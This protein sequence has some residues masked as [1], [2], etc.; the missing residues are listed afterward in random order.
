MTPRLKYVLPLF[1]LLFS[2]IGCS[3][4][5]DSDEL[6]VGAIL[7]LTGTVAFVGEPEKAALEIALEDIR[8]Q[9]GERLKVKLFIEDSAGDAKTAVTAANKL[10]DID[11]VNVLFVSLS[12]INHAVAPAIADRKVLHFATTTS[13]IGVTEMTP[14]TFR[15]YENF[16]SEMGLLA[17]YAKET[18][19]KE[20]IGVRV[21]DYA[22][23][24]AFKVLEQKADS[25]GVRVSEGAIFEPGNKDYRS[26]LQ[27]IP[28]NL[29]SDQALVFLG[30]G[31]EF[32]NALRI[33]KELNRGNGRKL[34]MYTF[35]TNAARSQGFDLLQGIQFSGF[36]TTPDDLRVKELT[37]RIRSRTGPFSSTPFI[38]YVY[39]YDAMMFMAKVAA[40]ASGNYDA[41]K[42]TKA[43]VSERTYFGVGGEIQ[44]DEKRD[45][46]IPLSIL[47]YVG[48]EVKVIWDVA[49]K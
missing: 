8:K 41:D 18:G 25:F 40:S 22:I 46:S 48:N 17:R 43:M 49:K 20:L 4:K 39:T 31:P 32:P 36:S 23:D 12:K 16:G 42:L 26:E 6:R 34:G 38:N 14:Y 21:H 5:K 45:A 47:E 24:Q 7:P 10:L 44:L 33:L 9:Y 3:A 35:L 28:E 11:K 15:I 37:E 19:I 30:Y 13:D 1:I 27:K 2:L 29:K